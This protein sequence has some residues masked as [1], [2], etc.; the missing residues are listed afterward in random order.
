L[1]NSFSDVMP[2]AGNYGLVQR[3]EPHVQIDITDKAAAVVRKRGGT[4]VVDLLEPY[5]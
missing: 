5:G 2:G 3:V 1:E 4:A